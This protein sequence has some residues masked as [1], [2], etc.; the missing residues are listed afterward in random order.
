MTDILPGNTI[1]S[2]DPEIAW[3]PPD[4]DRDFVTIVIL[5]E[6]LKKRKI[7]ASYFKIFIHQTN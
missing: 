3:D 1:G 6:N 7:K 5:K 2:G 4:P